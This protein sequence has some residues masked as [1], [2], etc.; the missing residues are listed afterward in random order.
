[1]TAEMQQKLS[2]V[3]VLLD[4]E[5][6]SRILSAFDLKNV[7]LPSEDQRMCDDAEEDYDLR[8]SF[9][10]SLDNVSTVTDQKIM[11]PNS[12]R[13]VR[14]KARESPEEPSNESIY[15]AKQGSSK[16]VTVEGR[17][18]SS[19]GIVKSKSD[20]EKRSAHATS[21]S[22]GVEKIRSPVVKSASK[23]NNKTVDSNEDG[24]PSVKRSRLDT[25]MKRNPESSDA[26]EQ[27]T[28]KARS[29]SVK[30]LSNSNSDKRLEDVSS[31]STMEAEN[32]MRLLR[33]AS[34]SQKNSAKVDDAGDLSGKQSMC[35]SGE[36]K[37]NGSSDSVDAESSRRS[38]RGVNKSTSD[39]EKS[40]ETGKKKSQNDTPSTNGISPVSKSAD[41]ECPLIDCKFRTTSVKYWMDHFRVAHSTTPVQKGYGLR[42]ECGNESFS[43]RHSKKCDIAKFTVIRKTKMSTT[44][45]VS[46]NKITPKC[47]LCEKHPKTPRGYVDHLYLHHKKN[48]QENEIYLICNCGLHIYNNHIPNNNHSNGCDRR[49]FTLHKLSDK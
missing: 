36:H 4:K 32:S 16:I 14:V 26:V 7:P 33:S 31:K 22:V 13:V 11:T 45:E 5:R 6:V 17:R 47:V 23:P 35:D 34:K 19:K 28:R 43:E 41:L 30:K 46:D 37:A 40:I 2:Q 9:A 29:R 24:E 20:S 39:A 48:L 3:P 15:C 8:T 42:C 27:E 18:R 44:V 21:T 38:S 10:D 12:T 1:R 49:K 25:V